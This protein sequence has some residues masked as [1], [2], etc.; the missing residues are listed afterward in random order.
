MTIEFTEYTE[1]ARFHSP[2]EDFEETTTEVIHREDPLTGRLTRIVPQVFP[3]PEE[4][5]DITEY[6]TREADEDCFFCPELVEDATPEYPDFVGFERGTVGEAISFP[7][8]FPYAKHSN[9]VVLTEEHFTPID[10]FTVKQFANGI[11]CALEYL[12]AVF[13][14]EELAFASINMNLLPSAG[15]S[16]VHPHMQ[17]I[18]DDH[19]T[20]QQRQ[21]RRHEQQYVEEHGRTYWETLVEKERGGERYIGSTGDVEWL[22]PFAPSHH[23][24]VTGITDVTGVPEPTA[25]IV[26]SLAE[27]ITTVL[28]YYA[29][30][31]LNAHNFSIRLSEKSSAPVSI[32]IVGRTPFDEHYVSDAFYMRT[33]HDE[34][35]VDVTPETYASELRE[36]F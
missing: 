23:W 5:P 26:T 30:L 3:Q 8:L 20:E 13:D 32:D 6:V 1:T 24:H 34:R 2:L 29:S 35:I 31:G 27:G 9:V 28:E 10:E 18:A 36:R 17:A 21:Q 19:G 11:S 25:G 22:A 14:H 4:E 33:L 7:N 12:N 16:I 15:S